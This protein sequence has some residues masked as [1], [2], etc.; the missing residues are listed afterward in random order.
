[1]ASKA[2]ITDFGLQSGSGNTLYAKWS[3]SKS[4]TESYQVKWQYCAG[5]K[6]FIGSSSSNSVNVADSAAAKQSTYSI[7]TNATSVKFTVKPISK[8]KS[9]GK[10]YWTADWST[11]KTYDTSKTPPTAPGVPNTELEKYRL[12][13]TLDNLNVNA[14]YIQFQIVKREGTS[15]RGVI[16]SNTAIQYTTAEDGEERKNG[17]ARYA[18]N[19]EAGGEYRVRARSYRSGSGNFSEWS[20]YSSSIFTAPAAPSKIS[21][22]KATSETSVY[23]EWT[24]VDSAKTY[25]IEYTTEKKYFDGSNQTTTQSGI[26]FNHYELTGL[27]SGDEYFFRVRAVRDSEA[28][29]WSEIYSVSVGKKPAAPTSWSSTT[30]VIVGDPLNLYWVHNSADGSSQTYAHL[31]V[32]ADDVK[33]IDTTIKNSTDE[34]EKD[35]TSVYAFD[36]SKYDEGTK[37]KWRVR[38][39]GVVNEF[40]DW[41]IQRT[42]DIYAPPTVGLTMTDK[43]SNELNVLT[44]FPAYIKAVAGP[45]SQSPIGYHV[46]ITSSE[47]YETVDNVGNEVLVSQGDTVYSQY[48]DT[49]ENPLILELLPSSINLENN[50]EYTITCTT[51]MNSGLSGEA[52]I[53]FTVEWTDDEYEPNAEIGIDTEAYTASITPYCE[54]ENENLVPDVTLSV[55]RREFDGRF[56]ELITGVENTKATQITD[57]HPALDFAR[58]RIVAISKTTGAVSYYDM[59]GYEVGGKSVILQ[60]DEKWTNFD[61]PDTEIP[62]EPSW[63]GSMLNLPYNIDVSDSFRPDVSL[64]EYIGRDHPISYYGTQLGVTSSWSME[65]EKD[66]EETLY[67][68][69][70]LSRWMGDVYVREPSGSGYWANVVVSFSQKHC[71]V[72]IPVTLSITRV[73]GGI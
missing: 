65:I 7:P 49:T 57:P 51:S 40:G 41:S 55:Y 23:L 24:A 71:E 62:V 46:T 66:D 6:W 32:Y 29:K 39:K 17:Y 15:F 35:K 34:D 22:I 12:T 52:T 18:Y 47:S 3:W 68:L 72:T 11:A 54:D 61:T 31:E 36:T 28:S 21:T 67:G 19:V 69:R 60:W 14:T 33:V 20:D 16:T 27:E 30:T 38:T 70:R 2:K 53:S 8:K 45:S 25:D 26:E 58:Y 43:D 13:M 73:E 63:S 59:P 4:N 10:S 64:V 56:T 48:F 9:N 44:A 1:M 42:V 5:G 50:I 37:L